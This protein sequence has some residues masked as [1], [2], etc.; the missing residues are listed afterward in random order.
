MYDW[1]GSHSIQYLDY[2]HPH[3]NNH[4]HQ[5]DHYLGNHRQIFRHRCLQC[6]P[7]RSVFGRS[8]KVDHVAPP[9]NGKCGLMKNSNDVKPELLSEC[10]L[11]VEISGEGRARRWCPQAT[12]STPEKVS[13]WWVLCIIKEPTDLS[14]HRD[15]SHSG[16]VSFHLPNCVPP[17]EGQI[18]HLIKRKSYPTLNIVVRY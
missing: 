13:T 1:K 8:Q 17:R 18:I 7:R 14:K 2:H 3:L 12:L 9:E 10:G 15:T 6:H 16:N 11:L 5:L 4:Q